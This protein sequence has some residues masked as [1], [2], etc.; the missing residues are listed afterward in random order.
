MIKVPKV[1]NRLRVNG[2]YIKDVAEGFFGPQDEGR[3]M[4]HAMGLPDDTIPFDIVQFL[5]EGKA[6]WKDK[7]GHIAFISF[8]ITDEYIHFYSYYLG[9]KNSVRMKR[10]WDECYDT[11]SEVAHTES[12]AIGNLCMMCICDSMPD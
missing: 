12:D 2:Y 10:D 6:R 4:L 7:N 1:N 3:G 11:A 8:R 9:R 5:K